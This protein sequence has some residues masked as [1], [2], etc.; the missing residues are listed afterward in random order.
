MILFVPLKSM[1]PFQIFDIL[2]T[3]N[4][5][6]NSFNLVCIAQGFA[7]QRDFC[8]M[9]FRL[10]WLMEHIKHNQKGTFLGISVQST[11]RPEC[12]WCI[13]SSASVVA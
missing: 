3:R 12:F 6:R 8:R 5:A 13:F 10:H 11:A 9:R 7:R 2:S 4:I 1:D